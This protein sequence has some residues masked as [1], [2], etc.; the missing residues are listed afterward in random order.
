MRGEL[1]TKATRVDALG[2][3]RHR[4]DGSVEFIL[5]PGSTFRMDRFDN[6]EGT[7]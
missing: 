7:D 3:D 2:L 5:H 1:P 6:V 4:K